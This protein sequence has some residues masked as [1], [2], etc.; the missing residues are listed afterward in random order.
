MLIKE[1]LRFIEIFKNYLKSL[2]VNNYSSSSSSYRYSGGSQYSGVSYYNPSS[3]TVY[4]YEWSNLNNKSVQFKSFSEFK[5]YC[6]ENK[7]HLCEHHESMITSRYCTY[8]TCIPNCNVLMVRPTFSE[9]ENALRNY[10][11]HPV[12]GHD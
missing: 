3:N 10:I 8:A 11:S 1:N 12:C 2:K 7:I 4:F 6:D 9:L 5:K